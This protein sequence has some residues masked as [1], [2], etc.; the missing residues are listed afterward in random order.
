VAQVLGADWLAEHRVVPRIRAFV[1]HL[2]QHWMGAHG[3]LRTV[4]PRAS[5]FDSDIL[6][7]S[8]PDGTVEGPDGNAFLVLEYEALAELCALVGEDGTRWTEKSYQLRNLMNA[9]M[10]VEDDRGG[11]YVAL[12]WRHGSG[13]LESDVVSLPGRD[14]RH[15]PLESWISLVPLYAGIPDDKRAARLIARLLREDGYWGPWGVRTL[16]RDSL[17]FQQ[18]PRVLLHDERRGQSGPVSN[19]NGPVWVLPNYYLFEGL[20]RYGHGPE[21]RLLALRTAQLLSQD[22]ANTGV[23][24]ECYNDA[25]VGLWPHTGTFISWN[26]LALTMLRALAPV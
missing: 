20:R 12:R 26:V 6:S 9:L 5:G 19:W 3:L 13:T 10:W 17:F 25:G 11:F 4:S 8:A 1:E 24:H 2:E 22:L 14:G 15:T 23:L 7:A 18:A 16:P 21:A